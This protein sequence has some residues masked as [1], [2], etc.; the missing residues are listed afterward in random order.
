MKL[1]VGEL[2]RQ[3]EEIDSRN[4]G[5]TS[6]AAPPKAPPRQRQNPFNKPSSSNHTTG[7]NFN[8]LLKILLLLNSLLTA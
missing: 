1:M 5:H 3:L 6:D 4:K 8:D 2:Q 7:K